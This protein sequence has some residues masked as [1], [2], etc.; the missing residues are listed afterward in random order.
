MLLL[1]APLPI[2]GFSQP[3]RKDFECKFELETGTFDGLQVRNRT[4]A[5]KRML[6]QPR[7]HM[8]LAVGLFLAERV[9]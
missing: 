3:E 9:H 8:V 5:V 2:A 4:N 7:M 6:S 1:M